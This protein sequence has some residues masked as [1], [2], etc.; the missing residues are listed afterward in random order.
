MLAVAISLQCP[1]ACG[2]TQAL[3]LSGRPQSIRNPPG[4]RLGFSRFEALFYCRASF[5]PPC[6]WRISSWLFRA[7]FLTVLYYFFFFAA[8]FLLAFFF[9]MAI[10]FK[11][12]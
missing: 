7:G 12:Y 1:N 8:F 9:A 11:S 3:S 10:S 6:S 2:S 4:P 5:W